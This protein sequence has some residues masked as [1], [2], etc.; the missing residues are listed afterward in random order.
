MD[1]GRWNDV[2]VSVFI[3]VAFLFSFEGGLLGL[4][5][6]EVEISTPLFTKREAKIKN[7]SRRLSR[8]QK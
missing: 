5:R 4:G 3:M 8:G 6:Q 2:S 7:I 1:F